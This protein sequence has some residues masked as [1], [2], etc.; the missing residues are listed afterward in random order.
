MRVLEKGCRCLRRNKRKHFVKRWE[1]RN[2][3]M[4]GRREGGREGRGT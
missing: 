4:E 3:G 1:G 2:D